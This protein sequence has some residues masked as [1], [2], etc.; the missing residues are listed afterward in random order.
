M[1]IYEQA[2]ALDSMRF[3]LWHNLANAYGR[4]SADTAKA[5]AAYRRAIH[6][7]EIQ[8][9]VNQ[10]NTSTLIN[11]ASLYQG[12]GQRAQARFYLERALA[13]QPDN[14]DL[15]FRASYTYEALRERDRA[16]PPTAGSSST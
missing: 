12:M 8:Y 7:A 1:R 2:V 3:Q 11:L 16:L 5:N 14:V 10:N 4:V 13:I 9:T 6:L 15:M